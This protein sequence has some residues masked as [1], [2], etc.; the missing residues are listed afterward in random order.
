[1]TTY[2][3]FTEAC[4]LREQLSSDK[5]RVAFLFGAGTS[6]AV[7]IDG[8]A[9]LT[10]SIRT[11]LSGDLKSHYERFLAELGAGASVETVLDRVRLCRELLADDAVE[12]ARGITGVEATALDQ[13]ICRA[14]YD[15]VSIEPPNGIQP[16]VSFA[17]WA[18]SIPRSHPVEV[19]TTNY[20]VLIERGLEDAEAPHFDGFVGSY[21]PYFSGASVEAEVG[22]S[23]DGVCPPRSWVRVWKLHGSIGW[24][25]RSETS[26]TPRVVRVS[27][28]APIDGDEL[29]IYP[30]RQKY[31]DSR[32]QPY[33]AYHD[34]LRRFLR[35]GEALLVTAGYAFGDQHIN[36]IIFEGLRANNRLAVTALMY[37]SLSAETKRQLLQPTAGCLNLTMY[38]A[39][40]ASV[41]GVLGSWSSPGSAPKSYEHWPFWDE[42]TQSFTLG[43]F[44]AFAHYLRIFLGVR[45]H[46]IVEPAVA[47]GHAVG[48]L[49]LGTVAVSGAAALTMPPTPVVPKVPTPFPTVGGELSTPEPRAADLP[50]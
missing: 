5:R 38:A 28:T 16:H 15:R 23:N 29:L 14:I 31:A 32:K 21:Q 49:A 45:E 40:C 9:P 1:M 6:Q 50:A 18:R 35:S 7:G 11:K 17:A 47:L 25:I 2:N 4:E 3:A 34:R 24:R 26:G 48:T 46:M 37:D 30:S 42:S 39:D 20:D 13:A 19:F 44:T 12:R 8:I 36:E 10:E 43:N 22:S 41:A 33:I 27:G